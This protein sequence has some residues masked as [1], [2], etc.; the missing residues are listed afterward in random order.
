MSS[1]EKSGRVAILNYAGCANY[2][3]NLTAYALQEACSSLG[4]ETAHINRRWRFGGEGDDTPMGRFCNR[5]LRWTSPV[6]ETADARRFNYLY[7]AFFVGSDQVWT[8]QPDWIACNCV[9]QRDLFCLDF[10]EAGQGRIAMAASF[11]GSFDAPADYCRAMAESL[12]RFTAISVRESRGVD[13]C[14]DLLHC[15]AVHVL[16]P[17]FLLGA[18]DWGRLAARSRRRLPE[19]YVACCVLH[20]PLADFVGKACAELHSREGLECV[21]LLDCEVEEWLE[22]IRRADMVLTDSFHACAFA[23]IFRRKLLC[24]NNIARGAD[25]IPSLF[26]QYGIHGRLISA[27]EMEQDAARALERVR[28]LYALPMDYTAL[29]ERLPRDIA[30]TRDFLKQALKAGCRQSHRREYCRRS[31][32]GWLYTL[33]GDACVHQLR[34]VYRK[35]CSVAGRSRA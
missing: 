13:I 17:V 3:A 26:Q 19:R 23:L 30:R 22:V 31:L 11:G 6:Y 5:F 32:K 8:Y 4:Y 2:G 20:E 34:R 15:E 1:T 29:E 16:D 21:N 28:E 12:S 18:D 24:L 25:R 7:D 14:R 10:V 35:L 33:L 9:A 27:P